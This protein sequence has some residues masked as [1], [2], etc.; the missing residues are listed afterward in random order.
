MS[1]NDVT[2]GLKSP[3][4]QGIDQFVTPRSYVN[5]GYNETLG[6]FDIATLQYLYGPNTSKAT[7]DDIYYL[8]STNLNGYQTI[9]DNGG[10]DTISAINAGTAVNIDL[11]AAT[12]LEENGGG[13]YLSRVDDAYI[14]YTIAY[15]T[16]GSAGIENAIGSNFA[17]RITG[18]SGNNLLKG[19]AGNDVIDG[20]YGTDT[21]VFNSAFADY[22][23]SLSNNLLEVKDSRNGSPEG[24]DTLANI[25]FVDFNGDTRDWS[26]LV[27]L[28]SGG[29]GGGGG[30]AG[31]NSAPPPTPQ[32][33]SSGATLTEGLISPETA[34]TTTQQPS[35]NSPVLG[36]QPQAAVS[37]IK[38]ETPLFVGTL[39][40]TQAV[41]GTEG[42]DII[43]GSDASE[44]IAGGLGKDLIIGGAG[45]D[46][47][48]FERPGEFGKKN[49]DT[50][51]DF[52][53]GEGDKIMI[54]RDAFDGV[55]KIKLKVATGKKDTKKSATKK[56][57]FI[58]DEKKG[59][60]YFNENQDE[61]GWGDGGIFA[62]LKGAPEL[63]ASDLT[64]V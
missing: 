50:I 37:T 34:V 61:E 29:G 32:P 31:V 64:L 2:S 39:Q 35:L 3:D 49:R 8:D 9:W 24:T 23:L 63:G 5:F 53:S 51:T 7:G 6:A 4:S 56:S 1:Y 19:G 46:G 41:V 25:E 44:V 52:N 20:G 54:S 45:A 13:G 43:T 48:L 55:R 10:T 59:L 36:I 12:L 11:R 40:L 16:T 21:A 14:G 38:L 60:L 47:F 22:I 33:T 57:T 26:S 17:D 27:N 58:Y 62:R 18:N 42:S 28:F 30:G 15:N